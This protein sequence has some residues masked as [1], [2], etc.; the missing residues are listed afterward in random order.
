MASKIDTLPPPCHPFNRWLSSGQD[1]DNLSQFHLCFHHS[2]VDSGNGGILIVSSG[3]SVVYI[4]LRWVSFYLL[5]VYE[6]TN[7]GYFTW[8]FNF[9]CMNFLWVFLENVTGFSRPYYISDEI[10]ARHQATGIHLTGY[11]ILVTVVVAS[12]GMTK[13]ALLYGQKPT[14]ATTTECVF[15]VG[16]VNGWVDLQS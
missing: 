8:L 1:C 4:S 6:E 15:G 7:N 2:R 14:E 5:G 12:V 13:S 10:D 11:R 3:D 16:I 9:D